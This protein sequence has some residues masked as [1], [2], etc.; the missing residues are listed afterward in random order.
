MKGI[1][2]AL[3]IAGDEPMK[4]LFSFCEMQCELA[5]PNRDFLNW[6]EAYRTVA[7]V[8]LAIYEY[9]LSKERLMK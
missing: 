7:D 3:R 5:D 1:E 9:A 2:D 4:N 6:V 8:G